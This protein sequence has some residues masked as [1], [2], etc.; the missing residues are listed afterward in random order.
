MSSLIIESL[1]AALRHATAEQLSAVRSALRIIT[2]D[3]PKLMTTPYADFF[4][5]SS[6]AGN[7]AAN[8]RREAFLTTLYNSTLPEDATEKHRLLHGAWQTTINSLCPTTFATVKVTSAG[9]RSKNYDFQLDYMAS[10]GT[11]THSQKA[12]FK[13]G[14]S[15]IEGQPQFLSLASKDLRFP[16]NYAEFY[17]DNYLSEYCATDTGITVSPPD[18]DTYLKNV[19]SANY[20]THPFFRCLYDREDTAKKAK[21]TVVNKS[22]QTY[23]EALA[24]KCDLTH[25]TDLLVAKQNNKAFLLWD[26]SKFH[27]AH[28]TTEN[29]TP[30]EFRGV[31]NGN[32][33]VFA[34]ATHTLKLLLRWKNHKGVLYPAW[35]IGLAG[36]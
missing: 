28:L 8:K 10:D 15:T 16:K 21:A 18:R 26:M 22:I 11:V 1:L 2:T 20:D 17:Y 9:G 34:T 4:V 36:L 12:E 19:H 7:D 33:I 25:L 27:V 24:D 5:K 23:M 35:Q 6:K 30:V 31:R 14:A 13:H 32:T 29:L 3:P